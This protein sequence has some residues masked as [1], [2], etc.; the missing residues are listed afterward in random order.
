M[1]YQ[2]MTDAKIVNLARAGDAMAWIECLAR[3]IES[4]VELESA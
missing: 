1:A 2:L 3:G 4:R